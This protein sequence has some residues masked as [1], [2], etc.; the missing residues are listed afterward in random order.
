MAARHATLITNTF[1]ILNTQN[2]SITW[3][4]DICSVKSTNVVTVVVTK[5]NKDYQY[6][7][8]PCEREYNP[9]NPSFSKRRSTKTCTL[10]LAQGTGD[11]KPKRSTTTFTSLKKEIEQYNHILHRPDYEEFKAM[12]KKKGGP[13]RVTLDTQCKLCH[14]REPRILAKFRAKD[15]VCPG[16]TQKNVRS[17]VYSE[18]TS[19]MEQRNWTMISSLEEFLVADGDHNNEMTVQAKDSLGN[20]VQTTYNKFK[21]GH[22]SMQEANLNKTLTEKEVFH[23]FEKKGYICALGKHAKVGNKSPYKYPYYCGCLNKDRSVKVSYIT[24]PNLRKITTGCNECA[25]RARTTSIEEVEVYM[26]M[27]RCLPDFEKTPYYNELTLIL[28]TC[29]CGRTGCTTYKAFKKG[30]RCDWCTDRKREHTNEMLYGAKN[31]FGSK[32]IQDKIT[33]HYSRIRPGASHSSHIPETVEKRK[34]TNINRYGVP[35]ILC[36][37][38]IRTLGEEALIKTA[39][40]KYPLEKQEYREKGMNTTKE[41]YGELFYV[42]TQAYRDDMIEKCGQ[43][44]FVQ[45]YEYKKQ[46]V[47][48]YGRKDFINSPIFQQEMIEKYGSEYYL[49]S[50]DFEGKMIEKYGRKDIINSPIFQQEMIEK[51]G[52]EYYLKSKD[53]EGKMIEKYGQKD[54]INSPIFQQEMIAKCGSKF[55][56]Q[57]EEFKRIMVERYGVEHASQ[58]AEIFK[59]MLK[60]A[61]KRNKIFVFPSGRV[62]EMMGYECFALADLLKDGVHEDDILVQLDDVPIIR[63]LDSETETQRVYYPDIFVTSKN[64]I[65]EVKSTYTYKKYKQRNIDKWIETSKTYSFQAWIYARAKKGKVLILK[66]LVYDTG[67]KTQKIKYNLGEVSDR[68]E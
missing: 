21:H 58:N 8:T 39:G 67:V 60:T 68:C 18:F 54:I 61:F 66:K 23:E 62:E 36:L 31:P 7:C 44:Y 56:I 46:M 57:S 9:D 41:R 13:T 35:S 25:V 12:A 55:F 16:C 65:I 38:A 52:S 19:L 27:E 43:E 17:K 20:I 1:G 24:I 45:S 49:K 33:E 11:T 4:C 48:K 37:P 6:I 51:Y 26:T 30:V 28:Y 59:K 63:Y 2:D 14:Y 3:V 53:F 47:E 5:I 50:K 34:N 10:E 64:L 40:T 22:G 32:I 29:S 42:L 15:F